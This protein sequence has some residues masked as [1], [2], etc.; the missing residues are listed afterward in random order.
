M[1]NINCSTLILLLGISYP[2]EENVLPACG[3][4]PADAST[5]AGTLISDE[6]DGN[7]MIVFYS[8]RDGNIEIYTMN[9]DGSGLRLLIEDGFWA[10]WSPDGIWIAYQ[11]SDDG[12][13]EIYAI[14][15]DEALHGRDGFKPIKLTDNR[16]GD[17]WPCWGPAFQ[18]RL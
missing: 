18:S 4:K 3:I 17:L 14:R 9:A 2:G 8:N 12:D 15:V 11:S 13:F 16:S 6:E 7:G 5:S 1:R 10:D